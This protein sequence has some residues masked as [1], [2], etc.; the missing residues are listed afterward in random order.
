MMLNLRN[1]AFYDVFMPLHH[2]FGFHN[3]IL[4]LGSFDPHDPPGSDP[5]I[6]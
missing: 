5:A 1:N 3:M 4:K 2:S 6:H